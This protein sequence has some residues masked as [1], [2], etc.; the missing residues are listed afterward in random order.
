MR[1]MIRGISVANPVDIK[2]DYLLQTVEYAV[3]NNM[4]HMQFIGPIHNPQKGNIDGM[5]LYRK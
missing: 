2:K 4:T 5:T 1:D 3:K